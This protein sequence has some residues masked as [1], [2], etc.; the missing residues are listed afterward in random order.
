MISISEYKIR[1]IEQFFLSNEISIDFGLVTHRIDFD[2]VLLTRHDEFKV[3]EDWDYRYMH[4]LK[5]VR[6]VCF[7]VVLIF[8]SYQCCLISI[9][10]N[11]T[12]YVVDSSF[13]HS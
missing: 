8:N 7:A 6:L 2:Y 13:F 11:H 1:N 12:S 5:Y 10:K 4:Q 9:I 3:K